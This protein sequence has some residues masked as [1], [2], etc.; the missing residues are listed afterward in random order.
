MKEVKN[1]QKVILNTLLDLKNMKEGTTISIIPEWKT[2]DEF[3]L[4]QIERIE[5]TKIKD[6]VK[7]E[8]IDPQFNFQTGENYISLKGPIYIGIEL[9]YRALRGVTFV[10]G[11]FR[12][13]DG[14]FVFIPT[15]IYNY[16]EKILFSK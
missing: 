7:I 5:I 2:Q 9:L 15:A 4:G 1:I 13:R 3:V 11:G 14:A 10:N 6:T 8:E 12:G 16:L